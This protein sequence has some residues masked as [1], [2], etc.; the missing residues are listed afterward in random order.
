MLLLSFSLCCFIFP[1][2]A[3]THPHARAYVDLRQAFENYGQPSH[4]YFLYHGFFL[5]DNSYDCVLFPM[6]IGSEDV[7]RKQG[8]D[9][10]ALRQAMRTAGFQ[11]ASQVT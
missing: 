1:R 9:A 3:R 2:F 8:Q 6:S 4:A 7:S 11:S 10:N 5:D